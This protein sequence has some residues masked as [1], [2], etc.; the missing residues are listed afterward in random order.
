MMKQLLLAGLLMWMM[1]FAGKTQEASFATANGRASFFS[2][3]ALEDI[4]AQNNAVYSTINTTSNEVVVRIP[5]NRF[6]FP[7][8]LMQEHFNDNFLET[9]KFPLS[10]FNGKI[11]EAIAWNKPGM[12][13]VT[14]TGVLTMHGVSTPRTITGKLQVAENNMRLESTFVVKLVDHKIKIPTLLFQKIAEQ[15]EVKCLFNYLP[16]KK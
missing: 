13:D 15:I 1:P 4:T 12:Y 11:N 3:A 9:D 2:R 14:A 6:D 8:D 10:T 7:N 5:V 16:A